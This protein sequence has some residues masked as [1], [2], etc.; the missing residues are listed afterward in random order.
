M[1]TSSARALSSVRSSSGSPKITLKPSSSTTRDRL[2]S[3]SRKTTGTFAA[4]SARAI[5]IASSVAPAIATRFRS[6]SRRSSSQ[7]SGLA[8]EPDS[9]TVPAMVRNTSTTSASPPVRPRSS[10]VTAVNEAIAAATIPRGAIA[11]TKTSLPGRELQP[12]SREPDAHRPHDQNQ[13]ADDHETA[14]P[15]AADIG[16]GDIGRQ[17]HEEETHEQNREAV[18]EL[19][20]LVVDTGVH[21]A[22]DDPGHGHGQEPAGVHDVVARLEQQYDTGQRHDRLVAAGDEHTMPQ[23]ER[24]SDTRH[25]A[26]HQ[27]DGQR[28]YAGVGDDLEHE[29][30]EQGADRVD[31]HSLGLENRL[32]PR[33]Q[34]QVAE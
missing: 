21:V 25:H 5:A 11:A 9:T 18:L 2:G 3:D 6:G 31:Q 32:E 7:A 19:A 17:Q 30:R 1:P 4:R 34:S 28:R 15:E 16:E 22:H 23:R 27:T 33:M 26:A 12:A 29:H 13:T 20:E 14:D 8:T 10:S 24:Q